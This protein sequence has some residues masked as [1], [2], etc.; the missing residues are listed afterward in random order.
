MTVNELLAKLA[1]AFPAFNAQATEAWAPVYRARL[2]RHEG[3]A[4]T[5]A[6]AETLGRFTVK[7][8]KALFPMPADFEEH[9]PTGKVNLGKDSGPKLDFD[10]RKRQADSLFANWKA[11]QGTRAAKGNP[12]LMRALEDMARPLAD[13][14]GW[15]ENPEPLVL[16]K[17]QIR[18]A[19][20]RAISMERRMRHGRMPY[21]RFHWW[22]QIKAVAA[23]WGIELTPERW[24]DETAK[25][26]NIVQDHEAA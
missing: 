21:N 7:S 13:V 11:R 3:P 25:Y 22:D 24:D 17:D 12:A 23:D 19:Y 16:T 15:K 26:L 18:V 5:S 4:L 2:G 20:Q 9:L 10:R 1:A 8:S 6:Y 14:A